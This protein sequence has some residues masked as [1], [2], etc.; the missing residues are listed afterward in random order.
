VQSV[1]LSLIISTYEQPVA[2]EKVLR[3]VS[4][5]TRRPEEVFI[6]DDGSGEPTRGLIEAWRREAPCKTQYLWHPHEG[7]RKTI[8]LNQAVAAA[9]GKYLVFLDGDCVPH[10]RFLAD[11]ERLAEP[12]YWVQGRRCFVKESFVGAFEAGKTSI[13]R[14]M[15]SGRIAP[16]TKGLY[17]PFPLIFRNRK[18]RGIIGCNMAFW[19][20]DVVAV[21]GFDETYLGRGIGPDSDLGT[22]VYNLGRRRKFVYGR[23]LVYHLD[24]P[25]MPRDNLEAK[26]T[27]LK[28]TIRSGKTRCERGLDQYL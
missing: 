8:L 16:A 20:E 17:L 22:R 28:E 11:H 13:W 2:L 9:T 14:W 4:L 27:W 21:N 6:T 12:G 23:A 19:R 3:G 1:T 24:H 10:R 26:R 15:L 25:V 5:Q 7:F 18:Q